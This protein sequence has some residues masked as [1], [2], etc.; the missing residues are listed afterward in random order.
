MKALDLANDDRTK[1]YTID[2]SK[3]VYGK[4]KEHLSNSA[5]ITEIDK[6]NSEKVVCEIFELEYMNS[7]IKRYS[8]KNVFAKF[9]YTFFF[10]LSSGIRVSVSIFKKKKRNIR[11]T[12]QVIY[13]GAAFFLLSLVEC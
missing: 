4:S 11:N 2:Y 9:F 5:E 1:T 13:L 10:L 6:N 8:G 12:L 3:I 7:L